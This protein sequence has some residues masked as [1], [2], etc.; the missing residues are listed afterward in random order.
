MIFF[1]RT[2]TLFKEFSFLDER[3]KKRTRTR[4]ET[5]ALPRRE[6]KLFDFV[7][8]YKKTTETAPIVNN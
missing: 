3:R 8:K 5:R 2:F 6:R 1:E 7:L 4:R